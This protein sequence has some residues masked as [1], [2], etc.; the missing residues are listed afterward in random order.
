V[1]KHPPEFKPAELHDDTLIG[2]TQAAR[3]LGLADSSFYLLR[4]KMGSDFPRPTV[5]VGRP[6]YR[7]GALRDWL[8]RMESDNGGDAA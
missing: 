5:V 4:K 3:F 2:A 1:T 7:V 8:R 6:R